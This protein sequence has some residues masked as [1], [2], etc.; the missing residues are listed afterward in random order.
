MERKK[1][2]QFILFLQAITV[3]LVIALFRFVEERSVA[4]SVA[5]L[6][7]CFIGTYIVITSS[8]WPPRWRSPVLV[9]SAI[10]T[11]VVAYPMLVVR[12]MNWAIPMSEV[13]IWGIPGDVFHHLSNI[14]YLAM[15]VA[16]VWELRKVTKKPSK[17]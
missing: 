11:F 17:V 13:R 7:F 6:W 12:S 14:V 9:I 15:V 10:F 3:P 8:K 4:A 5:G 16:T 2:I 1:K